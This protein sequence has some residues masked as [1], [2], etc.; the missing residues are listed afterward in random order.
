MVETVR[1]NGE[2]RTFAPGTT[3][4][5]MLAQ[6]AL[7]PRLLVIERNGDILHRQDW[8][9]T[10]VAPGDRFEIVTVVGGG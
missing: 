9:Q 1:V 4:S 6:L 5:A 3:V 7:E 8:E 10:T 2:E